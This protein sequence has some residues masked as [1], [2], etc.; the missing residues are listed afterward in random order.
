MK[1]LGMDKMEE[2]ECGHG[3]EERGGCFDQW[4]RGGLIERGGWRELRWGQGSGVGAQHASDNDQG[5]RGFG[6]HNLSQE[7][8]RGTTQTSKHLNQVCS[9]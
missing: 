3:C 7:V 6:A 1:G 4:Q 5:Q 9:A 8:K 2:K